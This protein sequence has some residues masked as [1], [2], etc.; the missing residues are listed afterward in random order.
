MFKPSH[1]L[2]TVAV[3]GLFSSLAHAA[4]IPVDE[5]AF[6]PAAAIVTFDEVAPMTGNPIFEPASAVDFLPRV[7]TG[8]WFTGQSVAA[9]CTGPGCLTG[10]PTGSLTLD[11]NAN[12]VVV[13]APGDPADAVL[14]GTPVFQGP[15]SLLFDSNISAIGLSAD[16]F[17]APGTNLLTVFDRA[18]NT[19]ASVAN[20]RAGSQFFGFADEDGLNSIAG[21]QFT[22]EAGSND[23][24][25]IDDLRYGP[26]DTV[27]LPGTTPPV[28]AVAEPGQNILMLLLGIVGIML[29]YRFRSQQV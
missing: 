5:G 26:A 14:T 3:S 27:T 17:N 1:A 18:G 12:P 9:G 13:L 15:I 10:N 6:T 4:L 2:L 7:T 16:F 19:L 25:A 11:Q 28:T 20:D 24:F 21:F 8:G 29:G 22:Y 23:G